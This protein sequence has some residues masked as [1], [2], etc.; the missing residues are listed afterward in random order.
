ML[1]PCPEACVCVG[2]RCCWG[3]WSWNAAEAGPSSCNFSAACPRGATVV[4]S[5]GMPATGLL[6]FAETNRQPDS[7]LALQKQLIKSFC[8]S[9]PYMHLHS[10]CCL[11]VPDVITT[12]YKWLRAV[13]KG[14][15]T[16]VHTDKVFLGRG[17]SRVLTAWVPLGQVMH[18]NSCKSYVYQSSLAD[19]VVEHDLK[20]L[21]NVETRISLSQGVPELEFHHRT[22]VAGK[23]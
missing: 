22:D 23:T 16:G 19:D 6:Q 3:T 1:L 13:C 5:N 12:G 7:S 10:S 17:S 9:Q 4:P 14:E 15:F 20:H 2:N 11:Q 8:S 18:P 21:P